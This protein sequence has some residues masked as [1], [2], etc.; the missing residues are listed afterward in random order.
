MS[1]IDIVLAVI[2]G[3]QGLT[4]SEIVRRTGITPHQ[5]VDQICRRLK[6]EG[7]ILREIG[8]NG[9]LV[10]RASASALNG[11]T[12][13]L[14]ARPA[15]RPQ[16]PR[17]QAP[18]ASRASLSELEHLDL[19]QILLIVA[20]SGS[21]HQGGEARADSGPSIVDGLPP[22]VAAQLQSVYLQSVYLTH[23]ELAHHGVL[24]GGPAAVRQRFC[25][26]SS[27]SAAKV[28]QL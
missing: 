19:N 11:H 7:R 25:S 18:S 17:P 1:N 10:N 28:C 4:D 24:F 27:R 23:R 14:D 8:P 9:Q 13:D 20:C 2:R 3:S 21:Q 16:A 12:T 6:R 22:A 15:T 5:Q 26:S